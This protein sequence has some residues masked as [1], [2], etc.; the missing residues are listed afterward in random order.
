MRLSNLWG[1]RWWE[2]GCPTSGVLDDENEV[3]Q[4]LLSRLIKYL[5]V[6]YWL[7]VSCPWGIS[8]QALIRNSWADL[9]CV[10]YLRSWS[11]LINSPTLIDCSDSE[12]ETKGFLTREGVLPYSKYY[13]NMC[14]RFMHLCLWQIFYASFA[15]VGRCYVSGNN[16][17][18][19]LWY[20]LWYN[21]I[22]LYILS[23][24][25]IWLA[26]FRFIFVADFLSFNCIC[27]RFY[28]SGYN[29]WHLLWYNIFCGIF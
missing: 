28:V 9:K 21:I 11:V 2:W 17:W 18:Q 25:I 24:F 6:F 7:S 1:I 13:N 8:P 10:F 15:F 27:G 12:K 3:V 19:L 4:P 29:L 14:G 23:S 5:L 20:L 16:L 26:Y 22:L